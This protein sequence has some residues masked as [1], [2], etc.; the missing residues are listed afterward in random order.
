MLDA[1]GYFGESVAA[2][3]DESTAD[4]FEPQVVEPAV[5]VLAELA[6]DG[7]RALEFGIGTGRI[8]LPLAARGVEVHGIDMSR[9]MVKRLREKPGG[10]AIGVTI[11]DF[12]TAKVDGTFSVA[13]LV[14]NTISNLTSQDA[15]VD[16]FLNAAAHLEPGGCFVIEV[17]VPDLRRLPPGQTAVPFRVEDGRFGFDQYDVATQSMSSHHISVRDGNASYLTVPFRYVWPSELDLM[18]RLAGMRLRA[19]WD[20]W[21]REPFT[22]ESRQHV[23][24][25]EKPAD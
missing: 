19:R 20:G 9:A 14:F 1:D 12:A 25:W 2:S 22:S 13:Y 23:S 7:G 17:G 16:C 21:S 11:G 15:Q 24:V 5:E 10:D 18:A 6:G 8:A 4:M 3:Y